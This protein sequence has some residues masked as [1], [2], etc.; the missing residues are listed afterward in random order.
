MADHLFG[1]ILT[2][3][4]DLFEGVIQISDSVDGMSK[5]QHVPTRTPVLIQQPLLRPGRVTLYDFVIQSN[6]DLL[7]LS[8]TDASWWCYA[9][10]PFAPLS[11]KIL[12]LCAGL[13][14][15]GIGAAYLGGIPWVSVDS[16]TLSVEH[17][18]ANC[19]GHVLQMDITELQATRQIHETCAESPGTV[20]LGFPCQ[21]HSQ[22]GMKLGTQDPRFQ[23]F[24]AGLRMIFFSQSQAAIL[25][26]VPA[27]GFNE[28]IQLGLRQ[29]ADAMDWKLL[30]VNLDLSDQWPCRRSRW[31][32]LMLPT[33]WCTVGLP[34]WP[35]S[36][37]FSTCG[38]IF[39]SWGV[40]NEVDE[41]DL[42]LYDFELAAYADQRYGA[43]KRLLELS[44]LANTILHS[45]GNA[46]LGCPCKCR[47]GPFRPA[48]LLQ[49]GLRGYFVQ[50]L[51]HGNPRFLH[52]RE[53][54]LLL[55]IPNMVVYPHPVR[56]SLALLGLVASPIQ[57]VWIYGHLLR[58]VGLALQLP[59]QPSPIE[60]LTAYKQ[61][62]LKQ[63]ADLFKA[64]S[65]PPIQKL[66]LTDQHGIELHI[67]SPTMQTVGQLLH[68]QRIILGWNE[69]GGISLEGETLALD[70][71]LDTF[72]GPY[73]FDQVPGPLNRPR[74]SGLIMLGLMHE[75]QFHAVTIPAGNF[76]FQA[77]RTLDIDG[78]N[79]L[80]DCQGKIYGADY[81]VWKPLN[82][83][84][85][86]PMAWP[87]LMESPIQASGTADT[88]IGLSDG[89]VWWALCQMLASVAEPTQPLLVHPRVAHDLLNG[90]TWTYAEHLALEFAKADGRIFCI[91]PS[92]NHWAFLWGQ[93]SDDGLRWHYCDGLPGRGA[94]AAGYLAAALTELLDIDSWS[95]SANH[96]YQQT[97]Q[98]VCGTVALLHA[99]S[100]LGILGLLDHHSMLGLHAWLLQ[101]PHGWQLPRLVG[102]GP[103]EVPAQ[104]ATLLISKGVPADSASSRASL[105]IQKLGLQPVQQAL[106]QT[107]AWQA[108]KALTTKPGAH[109]QF[110]LKT[111]LNEYI[112]RK[113]STKHG[114]QISSKKKDKRQA[115]QPGTNTW[116]LDPK[117]L[118]INPKH[119]VDS[120]GDTIAQLSLD[121]VIADARGIALC[122]AAEAQPYMKEV[123]NI[124]ADALALLLTEDV[125]TEARGHANMTSIRFPA[126]YLPTNDPLLIHGCL[127]Q[128]GDVEV[129]RHADE[130][131]IAEMDVGQTQVLKLQIFKDEL[132]PDW[133]H[134]VQS[135]IR[136]LIQKAPL[137]RLCTAVHCDHKCGQFHAAVEDPL[138]QVLLEIWGRR[139]QTMDGRKVA[140]D[141]SEIFQAFLRIAA[142]AMEGILALLMEGIYFEPRSA[143]LK[144]TDSDYAVVWL[145]GATREVAYHKLKL[146]GHGISLV[147][148]KHRFGIRV[149]A[150][151]EA[152]TYRELRP[153]EEFVKVEVAYV[154]RIHPVPHGLQRAQVAKILRDWH[155]DAK[156]LQPARGTAEGG[157]WD[158]GASCF[159]PSNT[160][161]AFAKDVLITLLRDKTTSDKPPAVVGPKRVQTHLQRALPPSSTSTSGDPWLQPG[162]DPWRQ[163]HA[164]AEQPATAT[165]AA[166]GGSAQKRLDSLRD[167]LSSELRQHLSDQ[168]P[169]EG[170]TT[171]N[172]LRF[173][174]LETGMAELQ[175][176]GQ[177]FRQWF[178]E[179]GN[180]MT[181]HD[182]QLSQ[183]QQ[184]MAQQQLDL[185]AVR[186][187]VHTSADS[188]H[189]AMQVSFGNMKQELTHEI[190]NTISSHMDRL[191]AFMTGKK[192]RSE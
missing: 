166:P 185:T 94:S 42:Q 104:L 121:Q 154:Y 37:S 68:A 72:T 25:E 155:W 102:Y 21:P 53:I 92:D 32:A 11:P 51:V 40:W 135:P 81:R 160:M 77:L 172:E 88:S 127:L 141:Q 59:A 99:G 23:V 98:H 46:L 87:P 20:T 47:Q 124:S 134:I 163:W 170:Y 116:N 132:A 174:K 15:M 29:L 176:Q 7:I 28:D 149:V 66:R 122:T 131:P 178:E 109:F 158:I 120:D 60:W 31:W 167:Q 1:T 3:D 191:E 78:V 86:H 39:Q 95:I 137:F 44:D 89:Q 48:T 67:L 175:A 145:P 130:D 188:L 18:R 45:Y 112:Q 16:N 64:T 24:W 19:H 36:S 5:G 52:P 105:A 168:K 190:G 171:E 133:E 115:K 79:F 126:T 164:T 173:A 75:G 2:S 35:I 107:N 159:P 91:Y 162:Q 27:A 55:G 180:K 62:L 49:G 114:A 12:E 71:A 111:E 41:S 6:E 136:Y 123:K 140:A 17:L 153:N 50:S 38:T 113:A 150:A 57:M 63:A 152:H 165:T 22:Q 103:A 69:A 76:L 83:T 157:A 58:N 9:A 10:D 82:L 70:H 181:A 142:P 93:H 128:L 26:C 100:Y 186:T 8:A 90:I 97:D 33:R 177:Q 143:D 179:S 96:I 106:Q 147:R 80:V 118:A 139:F 192:A 101:L 30:T 4:S 65:V 74:P 151:Y 110:V 144:A 138:D 34:S 56:S 125:P 146:A 73:V 14:G 84:T 156:P 169:G 117:Q 183:L 184:A 189:Q 13:G 85:L 43:D 108:L 129:R 161:V 182:Q 54:A 61:E 148:L 187:E 119:F